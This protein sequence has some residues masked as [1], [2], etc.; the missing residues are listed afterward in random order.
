M[1]A[2]MRTYCVYVNRYTSYTQTITNHD[3]YHYDENKKP[4]TIKD[5]RTRTFENE[6]RVGGAYIHDQIEWNAGIRYFVRVNDR[7]STLCS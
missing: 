3:D 5:S 6:S 7:G 1:S 2:L 4:Y